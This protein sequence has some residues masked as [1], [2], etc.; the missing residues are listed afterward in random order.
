MT[1]GMA[2]NLI[3]SE[4]SRDSDTA[5]GCLQTSPMSSISVVLSF[6]DRQVQPSERSI[7]ICARP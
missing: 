1:D 6:R 2:E 4:A 7:A 3:V 5:Q